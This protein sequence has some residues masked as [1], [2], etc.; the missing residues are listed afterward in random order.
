M[1]DAQIVTAGHIME[2]DVPGLVA[3]PLAVEDADRAAGNSD[4][5]AALF[6]LHNLALAQGTPLLMTA[7]TPPAR[8]G[9]DLPD[10][11]SRMQGTAL[12]SLSGPDDA[13]LTAV[14]VKLFNDRQIALD[15]NVLPYLVT[16]MD[17]S[18]AAAGQL[19]DALDQAALA[20]KRPITKALAG[21]VLDKL[22][23]SG[24]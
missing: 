5:E 2:S 9:L 13:L 8:W 22:A 16:R 17:R 18:F 14:L 12:V 10:L 20:Q 6:H 3:R 15:A 1:C 7:Q 11:K 23:K 24:A 4:V 19:V 21:P